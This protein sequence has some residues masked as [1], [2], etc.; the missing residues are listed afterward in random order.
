M[1]VR[2]KNCPILLLRFL[3]PQGT[4]SSCARSG[5][6]LNDGWWRERVLN[7]VDP[8]L[9][10]ILMFLVFVLVRRLVRGQWKTFSS[11]EEI[12]HFASDLWG[13]NVAGENV[14]RLREGVFTVS[15]RGAFTVQ[16]RES[17]WRVNKGGCT[18]K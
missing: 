16:E 10:L 11:F 12:V 2:I 15:G 8:V 13:W 6:T 5:T 1:I 17:E 18:W 3:L 9:N 4:R 14:F 7:F